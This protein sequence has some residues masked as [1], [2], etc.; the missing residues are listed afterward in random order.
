VLETDVKAKGNDFVIGKT[1]LLFK[2]A[3]EAG[4]YQFYPFDVS[5]DGREFII[6]SRPQ[7]NNQEITVIANW[8][9]GLK[10]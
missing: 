3:A 9:I 4:A 5:V 1:R 6:N 2:T 8:Q 10:N 7:G